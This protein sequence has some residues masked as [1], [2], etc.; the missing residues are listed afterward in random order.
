MMRVMR[1]TGFALAVCALAAASR[2]RAQERPCP[3]EAAYLEAAAKK[4]ASG[5]A[6]WNDLGNH[7]LRCGDS[8]KAEEYFERAAAA[9][10]GHANANL[11]L[12]RIALEGKRYEK[13]LKNLGQVKESGPLIELMRGEALY[14]SGRK[15]DGVRVM[16]GV[17][18]AS[19]DDPRVQYTAGLTLARL[20]EYSK[21]EDAFA[22]TLARIPDNPE[23]AVNLGRAAARA[24]H[25]E[26][27]QKA[28]EAALRLSP[29][30]AD[31]LFE[32]GRMY[33]A[34]KEYERAVYYLGTARKKAPERGE[35]LL[36]LAR[37]LEDGG[38]A[39]EA[40]KS[41]DEYVARYPD[42]V[43]AQRDRGLVYGSI[44]ARR[45]EGLRLLER[46]SI[47][48]PKDAAGFYYLGLL[49]A[50]DDPERALIE[51]GRALSAV[52]THRGALFARA[53]TLH[54]A[55]RAAEAATDLETLLRDAPD[56]V[57]ALDRLGLSYL[58]LERPKDAE[59]VLRKAM[60]LA[61]NEPEVLMHLGRA[62]MN[63]EQEDEGQRLLARYQ[64]IRPPHSQGKEN[65]QLLAFL[66]LTPAQRKERYEGSL[67][68]S[69]KTR[70]DDMELQLRL[71]K[72]LEEE[73]RR[74]DARAEWRS[75][76]RMR[77]DAKTRR[78]AGAALL[79]AGHYAD[80]REFLE[81]AAG[82]EPAARIDLARAVLML[83]GPERAI[84]VMDEAADRDRG[85]DWLLARARL[86][87]AAGWTEEAAS[88]LDRG[89]RSNGEV[90][91]DLLREAAILLV[92]Q[93]K[94]EVAL[95]VIGRAAERDRGDPD[96]R[97]T[98]S[99]VTALSGR[100]EEAEKMVA[101]VE[102]RWP[103]WDRP[104][105]AHSLLLEGAGKRKEAAAKMATAVALGAAARDVACVRAAGLRE[106][107][108]PACPR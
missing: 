72:F 55:G 27:A 1:V 29:D 20:G 26:R 74:E 6:F 77:P 89:L 85:A 40:M 70:P 48:H 88:T 71:A 3:E 4:G 69:L 87:D 31:A 56:E 107:L 61:P 64:S 5:A 82:K 108:I 86:Q 102:S 36:A 51:F 24:G 91:A 58:A 93:G 84:A 66:E 59:R 100:Q 15:A 7:H 83:E 94:T 47:S 14:G 28:F 81:E 12:A 62:L 44:P 25:S 73:G 37:A 42:D 60:A 17:R 103:E 43:E 22:A 90:R 67:R 104:Y 101:M 76:L 106:M 92:K 63:L 50:A 52:P 11:Q 16:D 96:L 80:A 105:M 19:G 38:Y 79:R 10:P 75:L 8:R 65:L 18:Q 95:G 23:V 33:G 32:M 34:R 98:E 49:R 9:R 53:V 21:A 45:D 39:M 2:L 99:I 68:R 30:D 54:N 13:A 78:E 46:Y 41:Y 97:L 57:Q 35:I